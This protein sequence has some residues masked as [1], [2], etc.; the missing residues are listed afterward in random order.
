MT[1][2]QIFLG[3]GLTFALAIG[4]QIAATR[5]RIPAI[6][7]LLPVGFVAGS[8]TTTINPDRL[9]GPAFTPM[10][11]L[12]VA[13]VLFDGG[14]D[15]D[16]SS[17]EHHHR[18]VVRRLLAVGVP[19]T[20]AGAG[21]F[22]SILLPISGKAASMLGA[23]LIVSGPT[24][25]APIVRAA[26]PGRTVTSVL[27]WEGLTVDP[28][29]AIIGVL[30]FEA[31]QAGT[32]P[33]VVD[34]AAKFVGRVGLG[35][36]GGAV[37]SLVLWLL[38]RRLKL[39]GLLAT[40]AIVATVVAVTAICD[41]IRADTGLVAAISM[42]VALA[43]VRA[44]GLPEDRP[45]FQNIVQLT[46]G[47]LFVSISATVTPASVKA[48]F[49]PSLALV[50]CLVLV[51]RPVVAL[52]ATTRSKLTARERV[53]VGA[54]DP[55]GIVAASTAASFGA[56]LV[57]AGIQGADRLLPVTFL[58]IVGTVTFYGLSAVPLAASTRAPRGRRGT[59]PGGALSGHRTRLCLPGGSGTGVGARYH[60]NRP[61]VDR[62][63][64]VGV[65]E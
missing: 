7:L 50:A 59:G 25:V 56:P 51:V 26:R 44:L 60:A 16:V 19:L 28:I 39:T 27:N 41:A 10:V 37:G 38:L 5:A 9:L 20:W 52:V 12:A 42:G 63:H 49:W 31:L 40:E 57:A 14:L 65:A 53:F 29:G 47:L 1:E 46:I 11:G 18:P 3:L 15:L 24:V 43:N 62:C 33:G 21:L 4:C 2:S 13:L 48:V 61:I 55:R 17:L 54:M 8:L 32:Q 34:A 22:A 36:L 6:I 35:L 30:V 64:F 45:F 23:I 58:V